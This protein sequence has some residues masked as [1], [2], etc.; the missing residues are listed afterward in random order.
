[1][2]R[3]SLGEALARALLERGQND[4]T[5]IIDSLL[6]VEFS[7]QVFVRACVL[8]VLFDPTSLTPQA[9]EDLRT[10]H[11][12]TLDGIEVA[13]RN[14]IIARTLRMGGEIIAT[15]EIVY[16]FFSPHLAL[17]VKAGEHVW[18]MYEGAPTSRGQGFWLS[19]IHDNRHVD[20]LNHTHSDRRLQTPNEQSLASRAAGE[21][22]DKVPGFPNGYET[23]E[24]FSIPQR[25][26]SPAYD[27]IAEKSA[28]AKVQT[29]EPVPRY[30]KR[31][32]DHV[33][34]GSN[35]SFVVMGEDRTGAAAKYDGSGKATGKPA[36]DKP[37][38]AGMV[39][40]VAGIG[41]KPPTKPLEVTN[42]RGQVETDKNPMFTKG[43]A[44]NRTEGDP[45]FMNDLSRLLVTM[46]TSADKN[47]GLEDLPGLLNSPSDATAP[48]GVM[49]SDQLRFIARKDI[50]IVV[51]PPDADPKDPATLA[52]CASFVITTTGN[53]VFIPAE[54][55]FMKF[56]GDDAD[57][58]LLCTGI[59]AVTEGGEVAIGSDSVK[60]TMGGQ[61]GLGGI[62]GAFA[63]KI[64]VQGNK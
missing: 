52:S 62:T 59:P 38:R 54:Q 28:A 11:G 34:A 5:G 10:L 7:Q 45:D 43:Q 32:G 18:V 44:E 57:R 3:L 30:N 8:D 17:P 4:I 40:I 49:K 33:L 12:S 1:M 19:R 2:P 47:F 58:A 16:P 29:V 9:I 26:T 51:M 39:D 13:P 46:K 42:A 31:P 24:L 64:L 36:A 20:D 50:K 48:A 55:G 53:I 41:Q 37:T 35:N 56:G 61:V 15:P 6:E 27:D 25:T 63:K 14:S 23:P 60:T 22:Q 21:V